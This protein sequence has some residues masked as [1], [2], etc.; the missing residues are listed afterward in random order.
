MFSLKTFIHTEYS[1]KKKKISQEINFCNSQSE[2][3]LILQTSKKNLNIF[4]QVI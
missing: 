1:K 2:S 3:C 4:L